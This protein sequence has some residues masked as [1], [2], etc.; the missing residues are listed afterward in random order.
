MVNKRG[1]RCGQ[2]LYPLAVSCNTHGTVDVMTAV[3]RSSLEY[4][5]VGERG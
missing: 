2:D 1:I 5:V 3:E 4:G